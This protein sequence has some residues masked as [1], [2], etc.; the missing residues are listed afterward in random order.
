M[1]FRDT[2][3]RVNDLTLRITNKLAFIA[4]LATRIVIGLAFFQAGTGK[5]RHFDNVIRFF[6]SLGIPFPA[7]HAGLVAS[8][9]TVGGVMLILGL[10]TRFFASGLSITMVVAL[11]TADTADFL[12]SWSSVAEKS[13]TDIPAFVFLLFL[14]WLV[15]YGA[16]K[17]SLDA[18]LRRFLNTEPA[19]SG[20]P[21]PAAP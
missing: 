19:V 11:M 15:F 10:F 6:D 20:S 2:V 3:T 18:V 14:V 13:P 8:M 16:D 7:F 5:F 12:A 4:P 1:S 9:E 17:L 21:S